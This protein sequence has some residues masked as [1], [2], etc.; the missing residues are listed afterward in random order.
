MN[1][2][3]SGEAL[4]RLMKD[5]DA[6]IVEDGTTGRSMLDRTIFTDPELFELELKY[7]FERNWVFLAHESQLPEANSFLTTHIGRQPV[8]LTRDRS[9]ELKC[10]INACTHRGARLCREGRGKRKTFTCPFHGW[11]FGNAGELLNVT[12]EETGAYPPKFDRSELGLEPVGRLD[13]YRGFIFASLSDNAQSLTDYLAGSKVFID[14]MVDQSPD[15]QLEVLR[16]AGRYTYQGNWKMQVENGLD[17][18]H[19]PTVHSNYV[20]TVMR[21]LMGASTNDTKTMS[22]SGWGKEDEGGFFSF[23]HGHALIWNFISSGQARPNFEFLGLYK[24][25]FGE[26]R[27]GWMSGTS[28][29]L[30]LFPNV[31]LMDQISSQLR[32]IRPISVDETEITTYC[33]APVGESSEAR[34][35]RIRQYEDFFNASGMAT[36]DDLTEFNN[37][38]AAYGRGSG[39]FN[40]LSRGATRWV[41]GAGKFG[42]G[43]NVDAGMSSTSVMDEG[44]Y[45]AMHKEWIQRMKTAINSEIDQA[46]VAQIAGQT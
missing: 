25:K 1:I 24:E 28:R 18:Y 21:R 16:G 38:Q 29:N 11:T 40:D 32:I 36:P 20:M 5:L 33:I 3:G 23:D 34:A 37:C 42:A 12:D 41:D 2:P 39:R 19:V 4:D 45:V 14:L 9:G 35:L 22:A 46:A 6:C 7:I 17:G 27:A 15:G 44:L 10:F 31:F 43:L 30:L 26:D 8:L 13:S